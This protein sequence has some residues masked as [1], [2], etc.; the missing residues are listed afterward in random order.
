MGMERMLLCLPNGRFKSQ[1]D[2]FAN[3]GSLRSCYYMLT[4]SS[5]VVWPSFSGMETTHGA[6]TAHGFAYTLFVVEFQSK[7]KKKNLHRT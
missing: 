2:M 4:K 1:G 5:L 6:K 3:G 7:K